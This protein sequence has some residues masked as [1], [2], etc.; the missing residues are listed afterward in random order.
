MARSSR[1]WLGL[2]VIAAIC[3]GLSCDS[4]TAPEPNTPIGLL[5]WAEVIPDSVAISDST[6][7]LRIRVYVENP[8][9]DTLRVT[10]GGPPYVFTRDPAQSRGLEESFR[11][12]SAT[13][14]LHAGPSFDYWGKAV[15]VFPPYD[16]EYTEAVISIR[17]WRAEGWPL[18]PAS[19]RVRAWF[20]GHEGT[21]APLTFV[22]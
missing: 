19:L 5:V 11:I 9:G 16:A 13:D 18:A 14:S 20:N 17:E 4:P 2:I 7:T 3:G 22:P 8:A 15:Y 21:S 6:A 1:K 12:A 10:S